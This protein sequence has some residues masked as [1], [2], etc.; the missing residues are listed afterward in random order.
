MNFFDDGSDPKVFS[1][2]ENRN[3]PRFSCRCRVYCQPDNQRDM[4]QIAWI[5]PIKNM[6]RGGV[7]LILP[8]KFEVKTNLVIEIEDPKSGLI[9]SCQAR[10]IHVCASPEGAWLTG[11]VFAKPL[12]E[13]E[14]FEVV[15]QEE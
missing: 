15:R 14:F 6:S 8:R 9:R 11:C 5:G 7:G 1:G 12:D 13:K 2:K 10:V 3:W 4:A